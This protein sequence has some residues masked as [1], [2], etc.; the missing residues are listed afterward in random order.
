MKK[1][2]TIL[3]ITLWAGTAI[4]AEEPLTTQENTATSNPVFQLQ[5]DNL[6]L[7]GS[8]L[9]YE[10]S[11]QLN[12]SSS[13]GFDSYNDFSALTKRR[14]KNKTAKILTFVGAGC[15]VVG[16][17]T[18][19]ICVVNFV[20]KGSD[21][22]DDDY[23]P[24]AG[25]T[26]DD[27]FGTADDDAGSMVGLWAGAAAGGAVFVAGGVLTTIGLIK[28]KHGSHRRHSELFNSDYNSDLCADPQARE[29][30]LSFGVGNGTVG[31]AL[32]F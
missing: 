20:K 19:V 15:M 12:E 10:P 16:L 23:D 24:F 8:L 21:M 1:L 26:E 3:A 25:A 4:W 9:N 18:T 28:W 27:P 14:K 17:T 31:F 11:F 29:S 5:M 32:E 13:F 2:F 30:M 7:G 22:M 6:N